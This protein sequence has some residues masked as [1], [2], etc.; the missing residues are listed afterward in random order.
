[1]EFKLN[2]DSL[3]FKYFHAA[4]LDSNFLCSN[5]KQDESEAAALKTTRRMSKDNTSTARIA[6]CLFYLTRWQVCQLPQHL[7]VVTSNYSLLTSDQGLA[8]VDNF[9]Y[10]LLLC[11]HFCFRLLEEQ[12]LVSN[13][14]MTIHYPVLESLENMLGPLCDPHIWT[15]KTYNIGIVDFSFLDWHFLFRRYLPLCNI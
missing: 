2:Q 10:L 5:T 13:I 15:F 4:L 12:L 6:V 14:K 3:R 1:M 11:F 7:L 9:N 8:L